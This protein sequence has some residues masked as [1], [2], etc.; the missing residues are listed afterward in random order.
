MR[1]HETYKTGGVS[2]I[3]P[4]ISVLLQIST[5]IILDIALIELIK[6]LRKINK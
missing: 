6:Y 3:L 4:I 5:L 1:L 2:L